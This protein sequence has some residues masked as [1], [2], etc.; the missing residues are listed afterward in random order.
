MLSQSE[1]MLFLYA[2]TDMQA[3][4]DA[5]R[6]RGAPRLAVAVSDRRLRE[7]WPG[8]YQTT[9]RVAGPGALEL[10]L[11]VTQP[12][13]IACHPLTQAGEGVL[14][15]HPFVGPTAE[16]ARTFSTLASRLGL[17]PAAPA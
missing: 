9:V 2:E 11:Q 10:V 14:D 6:L 17:I 16:Q 15:V 5:V 8:V 13:F 1:H 4:S 12:D 7:V 3:P